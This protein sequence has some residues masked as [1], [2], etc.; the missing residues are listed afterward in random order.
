[1]KSFSI[2]IKSWQSSVGSLQ[3]KEKAV[4]KNCHAG[5]LSAGIQLL[6][7]AWIAAHIC[8]LGHAAMTRSSGLLVIVVSF[9]VS[10]F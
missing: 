1:M 10:S 7:L 4:H 6:M 9:L 3:L 8:K 2:R 5:A